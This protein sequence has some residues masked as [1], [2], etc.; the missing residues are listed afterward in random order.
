MTATMPDG[1]QQDDR[2]A[3]RQRTWAGVPGAPPPAVV[4]VPTGT[5]AVL[6]ERELRRTPVAEHLRPTLK[7]TFWPHAIFQTTV[8]VTII[9]FILLAWT[10][11]IPPTIGAPADPL[12]K[13]LYLPRPAWYFY[14]LFTILEWMKGPIL[15]PIGTFWL[16]NLALAALILLPF[17]DRNPARKI[18]KRPLAIIIFGGSMLFIVVSTIWQVVAAP[19]QPTKDDQNHAPAPGSLSEAPAGFVIT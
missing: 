14:F 1:T 4:G 5:E 11:F 10:F 13:E 9:F 12:N 3:R 15:V 17:Y 19:Q 8:V 6:G 18:W 16:P 7:G 2:F